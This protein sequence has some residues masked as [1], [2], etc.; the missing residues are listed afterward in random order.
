MTHDDELR[1]IRASHAELD[2]MY[3]SAPDVDDEDRRAVHDD[4][5]RLLAIIDEMKQ[6][7]IPWEFDA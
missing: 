6:E 7:R 1:Q 2:E 4:R 5:G 3:Q